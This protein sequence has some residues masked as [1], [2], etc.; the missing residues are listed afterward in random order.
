MTHTPCQEAHFGAFRSVNDSVWWLFVIQKL[1]VKPV[2]IAFFS[3]VGD[4][5][6]AVFYKGGKLSSDCVGACDIGA[7]SVGDKAYPLIA[8]D[9]EYG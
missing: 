5:G 6:D 1:G 9:G 8:A 7:I 3:L 4:T 2:L